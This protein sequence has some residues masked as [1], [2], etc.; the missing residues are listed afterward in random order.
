MSSR[1]RMGGPVTDL[2]S[3]GKGAMTAKARIPER[4]RGARSSEVRTLHRINLDFARPGLDF[5]RGYGTWAGGG[6]YRSTHAALA[7][8][9]RSRSLKSA[10][11]SEEHT[12][13]LQYL[14]RHS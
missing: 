3:G 4:R 7:F 1:L 5:A 10:I 13:E 2:G 12:Y 6:F 14:S 9:L 8:R 11:S